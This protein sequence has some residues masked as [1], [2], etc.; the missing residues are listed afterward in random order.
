MSQPNP[1][2]GPIVI[3]GAGVAGLTSALLLQEAGAEVVV[4]EK[5]P[6]LGGLARLLAESSVAYLRPQPPLC[7]H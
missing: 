4:I 1:F 3:V 2:D 5:L 7:G 6:Q